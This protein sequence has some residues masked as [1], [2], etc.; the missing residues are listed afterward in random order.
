[1][2]I[3]SSTFMENEPDGIVGT[4]A[5]EKL[6][7]VQILKTMETRRRMFRRA[8]NLTR[9]VSQRTNAENMCLQDLAQLKADAIAR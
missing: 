8:S 3:A 6:K 2:V 4:H 1:M 7:E 9:K 5:V